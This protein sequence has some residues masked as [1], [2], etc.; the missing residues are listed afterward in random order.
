MKKVVLFLAGV[1]AGLSAAAV[2]CLLSC[3][4]LLPA[5]CKMQRWG[6]CKAAVSSDKAMMSVVTKKESGARTQVVGNGPVAATAKGLPLV[7]Q[8][9]YNQMMQMVL[10]AQPGIQQVLVLLPESERIN[11]VRNLVKQFAMVRLARYYIEDTG[12]AGTEE[13]QQKVAKAQ[14]M[15]E[16]ELALQQVYAEVQEGAATTQHEVTSYYDKNK[17]TSPYFQQK[18]FLKQAAGVEAE[19]AE[20]ASQAEADAVLAK[21]KGGASFAGAV[22]DQGGNV[23]S[24]GLVEKN[25][26][27]ID[28]AIAKALFA[29][30]RFPDAVIVPQGKGGYAVICAISQQK[31]E[32]APIKEVREQVEQILKEEKSTKEMSKK[33]AELEEEYKLAVNE[34]FV[35]EVAAKLS[36]NGSK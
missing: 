8:D 20:F 17:E 23:T 32:Y 2:L 4:G 30:T 25:G 33:M 1:I 29:M 5:W 15:V 34:D 14:E 27:S 24:L 3:H 6:T 36:P 28:H 11:W 9:E 7:T 26:Y 10:Q 35:K 31:A 12:V 16:Q 18:P 13:Y 21:Y 22:E 19:M